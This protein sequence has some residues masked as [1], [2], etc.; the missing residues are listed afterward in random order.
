MVRK[1]LTEVVIFESRPEGVNLEDRQPGL[2]G[3]ENSKGPWQENA[4][5]LQELPG[6]Q[7]GSRWG[8]GGGGG[9]SQGTAEGCE[10]RVRRD[11]GF[12]SE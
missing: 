6:G 7:C 9:G 4:Q 3:R 10:V 1:G 5:E 11:L 2:L 8:T 12:G